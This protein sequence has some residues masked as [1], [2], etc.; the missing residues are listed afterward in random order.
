MSG[1]EP[2]RPATG[3][4]YSGVASGLLVYGAVIAAPVGPPVILGWLAAIAGPASM[5]PLFEPM[6]VVLLLGCAMVV[7]GWTMLRHDQRERRE[8][9]RERDGISW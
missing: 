1:V 6:L 2:W 7:T 4:L 3:G 8:R 5:P 9:L